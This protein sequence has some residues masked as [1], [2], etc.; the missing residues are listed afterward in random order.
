LRRLKGVDVLL[1]ALA[2]VNGRPGLKQAGKLKAVI[3]G[4]GPDRDAFVSLAH[5]LGLSNE[6]SFPGAM[7]AALAFA[8]G[9]IIVV[10]SRNESFPYIVLEAA[11]AGV[12]LIATDVGGIPEIV[13]GTDTALIP[14]DDVAALTQAIRHAVETGPQAEERA[15]RLRASVAARFTREQMTR[16]ITAFYSVLSPRDPAVG[17]NPPRKS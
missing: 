16:E 5:E 4:S 6:V 10:P 13:A 1:R 2:A 3:V 17:V 11:A 14:A 12:P 7:P 9:R 8:L 15:G